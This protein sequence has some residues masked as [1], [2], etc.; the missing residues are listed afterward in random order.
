MT[1][2]DDS[3]MAD[4][5]DI[6]LFAP[7]GAKIPNLSGVSENGIPSDALGALSHLLHDE[8]TPEEVS[9][10]LRSEGN[11]HFKRNGKQSVL[12]QFIFAYVNEKREKRN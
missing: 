10:L 3:G 12:V 6:P 1:S 8:E 11:R 5:A 2:G 4:W 7:E 9:E